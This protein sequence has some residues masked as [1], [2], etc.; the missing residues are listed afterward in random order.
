MINSKFF[1]TLIC[2]PLI[3]ILIYN[4]TGIPENKLFFLLTY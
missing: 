1:I 4:I 3:L 2:S